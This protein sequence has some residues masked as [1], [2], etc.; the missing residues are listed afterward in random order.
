MRTGTYNG[1]K[2]NVYDSGDEFI[3]EFQNGASI[4]MNDVS[5]IDFDKI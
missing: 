3:I 5:E 1:K 4:T 2:V